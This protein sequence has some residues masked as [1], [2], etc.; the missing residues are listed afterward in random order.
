[1]TSMSTSVRQSELESSLF[2]ADVTPRALQSAIV[3]PAHDE[4]IDIATA[5][6]T[7]KVAGYA[8]AGGGRRV[9]QVEVSLDTQ[10]WSLADIT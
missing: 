7:Y 4:V 5:G 1:M 10:N 8:Y 9:S 2:V 6:E 3:K